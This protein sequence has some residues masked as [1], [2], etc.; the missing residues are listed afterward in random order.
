MT[1][2][3]LWAELLVLG[4]AVGF[5]AGLLG[6][7]GGMLLVPFMT[8]LLGS[9]GFGPDT[10]IK[11]AVATSLATICF[12]SLASVRAHHRRGAVDWAVVRL[13][14]PAIVVGSLLGAQL[15]MALPGAALAIVFGVFVAFSAVQMYID[16]KPK[17][18]HQLPTG[19]GM[20][21]RA[22]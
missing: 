7:G 17:P 8:F 12:T 13:R 1:D 16:R 9:R 22:T 5:L 3:A 10:L 11:V 14:A 2:W 18:A 21:A 20:S 6:I 4:C 19:P 15:A